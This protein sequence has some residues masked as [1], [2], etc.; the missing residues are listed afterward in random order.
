LWTLLIVL[1]GL[2]LATLG[3]V[4]VYNHPDIQKWVFWVGMIG[5]WICVDQ[6]KRRRN[7]LMQDIQTEVMKRLDDMRESKQ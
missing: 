1:V 5:T 7:N 3:G 2:P 6:Y 4:Y